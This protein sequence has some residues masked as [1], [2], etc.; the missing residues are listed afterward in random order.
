MACVSE[1]LSSCFH[2]TA[3][4]IPECTEQRRGALLQRIGVVE[5]AEVLCAPLLFRF[6]ES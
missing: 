3:S 6:V 2:S 1:A 4:T 5:D